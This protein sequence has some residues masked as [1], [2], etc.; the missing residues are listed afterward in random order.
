MDIYGGPSP[1]S[2]K[3]EVAG[4]TGGRTCACVINQPVSWSLPSPFRSALPV[5]PDVRSTRRC[6]GRSGRLSGKQRPAPPSATEPCASYSR[7]RCQPRDDPSGGLRAGRRGGLVTGNRL[8]HPVASSTIS[9]HLPQ[10]PVRAGVRR[11]ETARARGS[12]AL[13]LISGTKDGM[14]LASEPIARQRA[15]SSEGIEQARP[16]RYASF[17]PVIHPLV[18]SARLHVSSS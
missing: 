16:T 8:P 6:A 2:V 10:T 17:A 3:T 7:V 11:K 5:A 1:L 13:M 15:R 18:A 4:S 9:P 12:S 14:S